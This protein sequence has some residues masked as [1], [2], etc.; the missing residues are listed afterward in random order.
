M[1][2]KAIIPLNLMWA[3]KTSIKTFLAA[4]RVVKVPILNFYS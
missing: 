3:W 2:F 1:D 4:M